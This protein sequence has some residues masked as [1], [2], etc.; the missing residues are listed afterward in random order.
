MPQ[1]I[2][3]TALRI[4]YQ[5]V[6]SYLTNLEEVI[7]SQGTIY[8]QGAFVTNGTTWNV[9]IA[10]IGAGN[11]NAAMEAERAIAY[12]R[13]DIV[14]FVGIAGGIKDVRIGDVVAATKVYGY[15]FGRVGDTFSARPNVGQSSYAIIQRAKAEAR[16]EDWLQRLS[17][18]QSLRPRVF[19]AP[20][21]AGEKVVASKESELFQFI[22]GNYN[23]AI[24][25]EMEGFGFLHAAFAYPNLKK[26]VIRGISD[27]IDGKNADDHQEGTEEERQAQASHNATAFAFELLAKL[28]VPIVLILEDDELWLARHK[29]HLM[30]A[31]FRT[32]TTEHAKDALK[33]L[34][35]NLSIRCALIDEVLYVPPIPLE[36]ED[37]ELQS[38]QGIGVVREL[39]KW[40]SDIKFVVVTAKPYKKSDGDVKVFCRETAYLQQN[41][42]VV[43]IIHKFNIQDNP[44]TTYDWL[45]DLLERSIDNIK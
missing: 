17:D 3:L 12:F 11:T 25:L 20:I 29:K 1:V 6:R 13:P 10:E 9:V 16:K 43:A 26:I 27:L 19:V 38:L 14:L 45:V 7:N 42:G 8:E 24:A 5:A 31:G 15:E 28:P 34:K 22:R 41:P 18:G 44:E 33:S 40:R 39:R 23:D 30:K 4:E 32:H 35:N 37:R 2:I 36:E 21:A